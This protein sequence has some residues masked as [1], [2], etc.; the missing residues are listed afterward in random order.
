MQIYVLQNN[1]Q[2]ICQKLVN[3]N[4]SICQQPEQTKYG[5]P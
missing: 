1:S 2:L 5:K 3:K 4:K